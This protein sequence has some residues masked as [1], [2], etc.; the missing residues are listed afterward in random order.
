MAAFTGSVSEQDRKVAADSAG[1]MQDLAVAVG[2]APQRTL[3]LSV[4]GSNQ[5]VA[6]PSGIVP[7]LNVLLRG[8]AEGKLMHLIPADIT[9]TTQQAAEVLQLHH[10][11]V[12]TLVQR[13]EIKSEGSDEQPRIFLSEVLKYHYD[14]QLKRRSLVDEIYR[15]GQEMESEAP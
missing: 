7:L 10:P 9:L 11:Y 1:Q 12:L 14:V 6:L 3:R 15:L 2:A 8:M 4:E 13:G 5:Y